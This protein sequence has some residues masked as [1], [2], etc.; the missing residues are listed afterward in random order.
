MEENRAELLERVNSQENETPVEEPVKEEAVEDTKVDETED[1]TSIPSPMNSREL[2]ELQQMVKSAVDSFK[3]MEEM[4]KNSLE[5]RDVKFK[6]IEIIEAL[7]QTNK[8][9]AEGRMKF[10][11]DYVADDDNLLHYEL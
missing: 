10:E 3:A 2:K 4:T 11:Y 9:D 1:I 8:E 6:A 5:M 7:L